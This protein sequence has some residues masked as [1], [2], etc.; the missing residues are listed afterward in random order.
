MVELYIAEI[1][2][3]LPI[4]VVFGRSSDVRISNPEIFLWLVVNRRRASTHRQTQGKEVRSESIEVDYS[5]RTSRSQLLSI[6]NRRR[7]DRTNRFGIWRAATTW[8][9]K[10]KNTSPTRNTKEKRYSSDNRSVI[11]GSAKSA[12]RRWPLKTDA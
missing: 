10:S 5:F 12:P 8:F 7:G 2:V 6:F 9:W 1:G 11:N 3:F 4:L